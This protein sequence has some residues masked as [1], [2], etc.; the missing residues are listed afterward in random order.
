MD[1]RTRLARRAAVA[2]AEAFEAKIQSL[3]YSKVPGARATLIKMATDRQWLDRAQKA[4]QEGLTAN[5][6]G[7]DGFTYKDMMLA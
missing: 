1:K 7:R 3:S 2:K 4:G 6:R 5:G